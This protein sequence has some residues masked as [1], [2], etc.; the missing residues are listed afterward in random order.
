MRILLLLALCSLITISC[1]KGNDVPQNSVAHKIYLEKDS[2]LVYCYADSQR[3][4]F[5][6]DYM[7]G[8]AM[9]MMVYHIDSCVYV[10]GDLV[11]NSDG[12]TVRYQLYRVN[13]QTLE[14][15]H[16]GDFAAIH[17]EDDGFKA[18]TARLTN[19]D[20]TCTA[21]EVFVMRDNFY[22]HDG[23]LIRKG[24]DEYSYDDMIA[25][26]SDSLVNAD[27]I[28]LGNNVIQ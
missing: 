3:V 10:I 28:R 24:E 7:D 23:T 1:K 13:A 21:D 25:Q 26:Y 5:N 20:A 18:A 9:A 22:S 14:T 6:N 17:F 15:K 12:W 16:I 8:G 4:V 19:P 2:G 11:P 27:G